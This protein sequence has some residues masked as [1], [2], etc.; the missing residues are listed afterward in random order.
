[1]KK[2]AVVEDNPDNRLL[3]Q[4]ILEETY[5][6][7]EYETGFTALEQIPVDKPD[8]VLLDILMYGTDGITVLKELRASN[9]YLPV[10]MI[11]GHGSMESVLDALRAGASD[12]IQ[13]P[14]LGEDVVHHIRL[15][16]RSEE[17]HRLQHLGESNAEK[18]A[19]LQTLAGGVAHDLNNQLTVIMSSTQE[20]MSLIGRGDPGGARG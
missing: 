5:E 7:V 17:G 18:V 11:T 13:K 8:A 12:Y 14:A 6:I 16:I 9:P 20:L 1:M 4:V 15:A 3:V 2:I 10:V 19:S